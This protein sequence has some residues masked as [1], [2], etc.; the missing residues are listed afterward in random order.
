MPA[1]F[2]PSIHQPSGEAGELDQS[3]CVC[4]EC[5]C[6][7]SEKM[8]EM[9]TNWIG[10]GRMCIVLKPSGGNWLTGSGRVVLFLPARSSS[11]AVFTPK[12]GIRVSAQYAVLR[13]ENWQKS[14]HC[15]S[16]VERTLGKGEVESSNLS[17]G[18]PLNNDPCT[19]GCVEGLFE[20]REPTV[21]SSA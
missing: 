15:S 5:A 2:I 9:R 11:R 3:L 16:V 8:V 18:F 12:I 7:E 14:R 13:Q 4:H 19:W 21:D 10:I 20:N 6:L 1:V 17:S